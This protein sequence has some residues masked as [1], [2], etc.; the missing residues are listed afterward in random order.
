[1][2]KFGVTFG[3]GVKAFNKRT[4]THGKSHEIFIDLGS[5]YCER[6]FFL[7]VLFYVFYIYMYKICLP[8]GGISQSE[9]L[10]GN[11]DAGIRIVKKTTYDA[12]CGGPMRHALQRH[13][14]VVNVSVSKKKKLN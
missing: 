9:T 3:K 11:Q 12:L 5:A 1:M 8:S 13:E 10:K 6:A 7:L 14:N 2:L 4:T